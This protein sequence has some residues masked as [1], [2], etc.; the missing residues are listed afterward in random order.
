MEMEKLEKKRAWD[1]KMVLALQKETV[2]EAHARQADLE[3]KDAMTKKV[4][5]E[6]EEV[7]AKKLAMNLKAQ[8]AKEKEAEI[9]K[10]SL[11]NLMAQ[12]GNVKYSDS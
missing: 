3:A 10:P 11:V 9:A 7:E 2:D 5:K 1:A 12:Q 8:P 4:A 6:Q